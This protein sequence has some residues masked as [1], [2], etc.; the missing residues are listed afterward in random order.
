MASDYRDKGRFYFG[1]KY[2]WNGLLYA[3]KSERNVK[4]H[5]IAMI[6]V[7][8]LGILT[9]LS[10]IEWAVLCLTCSAVISMEVLNTAVETAL[11]YLEPNKKAAIGL[12]KDLAAG[13]VLVTA[14]FAVIIGCFIF[15]PHWI[16]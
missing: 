15:L 10:S 5:L 2:A 16:D 11:N 1:F 9:K 3:I 6:I 7:F 4:I 8:I 14:I 12:A 13:A